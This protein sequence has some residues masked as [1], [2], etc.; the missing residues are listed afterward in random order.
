M[1]AA[2]NPPAPS[3]PYER[4][5]TCDC[6][7]TFHLPLALL[8]SPESE[9]AHACV[10][11][12]H[13]TCTD[14]LWTHI[15]H[16]TFEPHGRREYAISDEVRAWLD[17]WPRVLRGNNFD[18]YAFLP[19]RVRCT[20]VTDFQ[21]QAARAFSAARSE[22]RGRLL[23]EAGIPS[24]P[25]PS[26][27]PDQLKNYRLLWEFSR[28]LTPTSDLTILLE[29]ARPSYQLSSPLA[30]DALLRRTDLPEI[31]PRAAAS[32]EHRETVCALVQE[33]PSTLPHALPG[34]LASLDRALSQ[35]SAP[36]DYRVHALLDFF[37]KQ[38]PAAAQIV[39]A[40]EVI[41]SR[42]DRRAY[43]LSR[44]LSETIRA[45]NGEPASPV[46]TKPWFFN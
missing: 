32:P 18:D 35:P 29:N 12:G 19:A 14:V 46:S 11:C 33:D 3:L 39:P 10:R 8:L 28:E 37:A 44:K 2:M 42:L 9:P 21:L 40:L 4:A 5:V 17:L 15:H 36:D 25:P 27:L 41:K 22:P 30:L 1:P 45:L 24:A 7:R 31:L 34:L 26:S 38:K 43:E 20:D 23:R 13:I 6:D 16:N